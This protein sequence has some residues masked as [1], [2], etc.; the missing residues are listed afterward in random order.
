MADKEYEVVISGVSGFFPE[1]DGLEELERN[2][3]NKVNMV[4][5]DGRRWTPGE[6]GVP[7]GTGKVKEMNYFD[8]TFFGIHRKLCEIMDPTTRLCLEHAY[9]AVCDAGINPTLLSGTK[10]AVAM[11]SMISETEYECVMG[12]KNVG[13][14]MLGHSRT[15]QANRLSYFMN[16]KGPSLALDNTW[17]GGMQA[18]EIGYNMIK[19]GQTTTAIVGVCSLI[20]KAESSTHWHAKGELNKDGLTKCF[21][22]DADGYSRAEAC[23]VFFLQRKEHAKRVYASLLGIKSFNFGSREVGFGEFDEEKYK[24]L[25]EDVYKSSNV[26]PNDVAYVEAHG[27]ASKII[28]AKELNSLGE[29]L[30]TKRDKPLLI[31]SVKS[32]LGHTEASSTFVSICKALLALRSGVIAP[33]INYNSPNPDVP[34]L[35]SGKLK[36]ITEPTKLEGDIIG[37]SSNGIAGSYG[38]VLLKGNPKV[39]SRPLKLGELPPDGLPRLIILS[40]RDEAALNGVLTKLESSPIDEEFVAL[41]HHLFSTEIKRHLF[42]AYTLLGDGSKTC[43]QLKALDSG[44]KRPIWFVFSGMGSQWCGMGTELLKLPCFARAIHKCQEVLKPEGIDVIKIITSQDQKMFDNILHSFVGIAAVQIGLVDTLK[45]LGIEPDGIIGHSVGELGCAYADGCFTLEQMILSAYARGR[46]SIETELIKGKMAAVGMGYN[47]IKNNLPPAIEVACH[48]AAESCTLSGP[49]EDMEVYI[50]ELKSQGVFAKLVNVSNIAYHSKHIKPAAPALLKYLKK[51]IPN[52]QCRSKRWISS[53]IPEADWDSD[54]AKYSSAEYHTNNLLSS[55]LFE[56][57]SAHIPNNAIVIEIAPHGLLQ[58]ILK[59]S[60]PTCTNIPLTSRFES[61]GIS[62]LLQAIG[63]MYL[64]GIDVHL[65]NLYPT[66]E[67][68]V[69]RDTKYTSSV[70][71]WDHSE[72]W[73]IW[74]FINRND[75]QSV[76]CWKFVNVSLSEEKFETL[77]YNKV[78]NRII[79]PSSSLV[80]LIIERFNDLKKNSTSPIKIEKLKFCKYVEVPAKS[81]KELYVLVQ[82]GSGDFQICES[83]DEVVVGNISIIDNVSNLKDNVHF[84]MDD[85]YVTMGQNEFYNY[86]Y[87]MG[88]NQT[89]LFRSVQRVDFNESGLHAKIQWRGQWVPFLDG[90]FKVVAFFDMNNSNCLKLITDIEHICINFEAFPVDQKKEITVVYNHVTKLVKCQ[91]LEILVPEVN[92]PSI[93]PCEMVL[94]FDQYKFIPYTNSSVKSVQDIVSICA[95]TVYENINRFRDG[96]ISQLNIIDIQGDG[97]FTESIQYAKYQQNQLEVSIKQCDSDGMISSFDW[98]DLNKE[99]IWVISGCQNFKKSIK[100]LKSAKQSFFLTRL[101]QELGLISQEKNLRSIFNFNFGNDKV[102]LYKLENPCDGEKHVVSALCDNWAEELQIKLNTE[103][104]KEQPGTIYIVGK[105]VCNFLSEIQEV[106]KKCD[107]LDQSDLLRIYFTDEN[108]PSF[109]LESPFYKEQIKKDLRI[110]ICINNEWGNLSLL[111]IEDKPKKNLEVFGKNL[112]QLSSLKAKDFQLSA[113]GLNLQDITAH[114][115]CSKFGVFDYAGYN[116]LGKKV[117]GVATLEDGNVLIPDEK[118]VWNKPDSWS[119]E[120]AAAVPVF[121][122]MAYHIILIF[123][124]MLS[125]SSILVHRGGLPISQSI[126]TIALVKGFE[127]FTTYETEEEKCLIKKQFP[128]IPADHILSCE[129]W[130]FHIELLEKTEGKGVHIVVNTLQNDDMVEASQRCI[131]NQGSFFQLSLSPM[132]NKAPMGMRIFLKESVV[133]GLL[134]ENILQMA[135]YI[136]EK[137]QKAMAEGLV[138]GEVKPLKVKRL[139]SD[140]LNATAISLMK[141][142]GKVNNKMVV[143][144]DNNPGNKKDVFLCDP[145]KTYLILGG[146]KAVWLELVEWLI[147]R[148]AK[149]I[150]VVLKKHILNSYSAQRLNSMLNNYPDVKVGM[151]SNKRISSTANIENLYNELNNIKELAAVFIIGN[152]MKDKIVMID[153][154]LREKKSKSQIVCIGE[155]GETVCER[156]R[157]NQLPAL[158]VNCSSNL[159]PHCIVASLDWLTSQSNNAPVVFIR[160]SKNLS[161]FDVISKNLSYKDHMPENLQELLDLQKM[162]SDRGCFVEMKA[163][164]PRYK[165]AKEVPP[166][167]LFNGLKPNQLTELASKFFYPTFQAVLPV[168]FSS[169]ESV[170]SMLYE[171]LLK[172][173]YNVFTLVADDWGGALALSVAKLLE[174]DGKFVSVIMLD[175]APQTV[176]EWVKTIYDSNGLKMISKYIKVHPKV[177][178]TLSSITN[179]DEVLDTALN[180]SLVVLDEKEKIKEAIR[181]LKCQ[182]NAIA[183]FEGSETKVNGKCHLLRPN[184]PENESEHCQLQQHCKRTVKIH[185]MDDTIHRNMLKNDQTARIIN[186]LVFFEYRDAANKPAEEHLGVNITH[187]IVYKSDGLV[188]T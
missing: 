110:N 145:E 53:S 144:L 157:H 126:I 141:S 153:Q 124:E 66:V 128:Q 185:L 27:C 56:E 25:V 169:I 118:L 148:G 170:A 24:V 78:N 117:M 44:V 70:I 99:A 51:V 71:T 173:P 75:L 120:E 46:A 38:H 159:N 19:R 150:E 125:Y 13:H 69:S 100:V 61:D 84:E 183:K 98:N 111:P 131:K 179:F 171:E 43:H 16:L 68:P 72:L 21:S 175:A 14:A 108:C 74:S 166:L 20:S 136:K 60:L 178:K 156:R 103:A 35:A 6:L 81:H 93:E 139:S 85:T 49:S 54:L 83:N 40:G 186:E 95:T 2:L 174:A 116:K 88:I 176:Q 64:E 160:E 7:A 65:A 52:P 163:A 149:N 187:D 4:T 33:N 107:S 129:S 48:N 154:V 29:A 63:R 152:G 137:I 119:D 167:F 102:V 151:M 9:A 113:V 140:L 146:H 30:C 77:S 57:A 162:K 82:I 10:T 161:S 109:D 158:S 135:D 112:F 142:H 22:A 121:Y 172:F 73:I 80:E 47:Q 184:I 3:L 147:V 79:M 115:Q 42:R 106:I 123:N 180:N 104:N 97:F 12:A 62:F 28:D 122:T 17:N 11:A 39:K 105:T 94:S 188:R 90:I 31:G 182:L 55:V 36:V 114:S 133:F 58:A 155:G 34:W 76:P 23:V 8:M 41:T 181:M 127:V 50:N 89:E 168:E 130:K 59:R 67:F 26:D 5:V 101:T 1:S 177:K 91:G 86:L 87:H 134:P 165:F 138:K 15:M 32:N 164:C 92:Q 45:E 37:I 96:G 132:E 143:V 18:L